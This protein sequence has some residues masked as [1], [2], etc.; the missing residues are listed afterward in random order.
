MVGPAYCE[1][2][3]NVGDVTNCKKWIEIIGVQS[4]QAMGSLLIASAG[5]I[6]VDLGCTPWNEFFF[7]K[8]YSTY[9][10]VIL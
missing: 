2:T 4:V 9:I 7:F 6:C 10:I 3:Y 1:S 8:I 5:N